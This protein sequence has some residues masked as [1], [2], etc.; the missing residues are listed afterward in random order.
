M[1]FHN[2]TAALLALLLASSF[3]VTAQ[4]EP[5][6]ELR[7]DVPNVIKAIDKAKL[8]AEKQAAAD[9][10][11]LG[12]EVDEVMPVE[13]AEGDLPEEGAMG[14]EAF[15][16]IVKGLNAKTA[17]LVQ[18]VK[19]SEVEALLS[20]QGLIGKVLDKVGPGFYKFKE[21]PEAAAAADDEDDSIPTDR[22]RLWILKDSAIVAPVTFVKS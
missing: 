21:D 19:K 15:L 6:L 5:Y 4:D 12:I 22:F 16:T 10:A 18:G 7:L 17:H 9:A 20:A 1:K 14:P 3:S 2:Y 11:E 13:D 8:K